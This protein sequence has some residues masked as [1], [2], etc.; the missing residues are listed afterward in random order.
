VISIAGFL[1]VG[2][3]IVGFLIVMVFLMVLT[4]TSFLELVSE[5]VVIVDLDSDDDDED[6]VWVE[7]VLDRDFFELVSD[8]EV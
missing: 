3:L 4:L 2:T 5:I 8:P 7:T 6:F 1:I